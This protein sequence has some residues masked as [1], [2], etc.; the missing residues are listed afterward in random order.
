MLQSKH[1]VTEWIKKQDPSICCLQQTHF[2]PTDTCKLKAKWWKNI[3]H[4]S[5]S[6]KKAGVAILILD[7]IDCKMKTV[8]KDNEGHFIV[9]KRSI[10]Q[11]DITIVKYASN[12]GALNI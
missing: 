8:T 7:K 1:K 4:A 5:G 2:R 9:I 12:I 11:E 3:Y 6:R 10:Q